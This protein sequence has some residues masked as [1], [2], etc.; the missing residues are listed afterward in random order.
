MFLL[1]PKNLSYKVKF[2]IFYILG[3]APYWV[4]PGALLQQ[5]PYF[6]N[7]FPEGHKI[8]AY[9]NLSSSFGLIF[10]YMYW[11]YTKYVKSIPHKLAVPGIL[12]M[13]CFVGFLTV[14]IFDL[15]TNKV[16]IGLYLSNFFAGG[17]GGL[18]AVIMNPFMSNYGIFN[19]LNI[20]KICYEFN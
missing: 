16:S 14:G 10:V 19:I 8:A 4:F 15:T 5:V 3:I 9:L 1:D 11:M 13:S 7:N 6:E 12:G 2:F 20:F 18:S 17:V